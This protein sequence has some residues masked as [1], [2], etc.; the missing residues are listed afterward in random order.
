MVVADDLAPIWGQGISNH[1]D[2]IGRSVDVMCN[3]ETITMT[4][5]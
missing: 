3:A 2:N 4:S 1:P 5:Q